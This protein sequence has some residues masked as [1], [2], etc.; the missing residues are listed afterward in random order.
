MRPRWSA[1]RTRVPSPPRW[2][3]LLPAVLALAPLSTAFPQPATAQ[4]GLGAVVCIGSEPGVVAGGDPDRTIPR[5]EEFG[6][7]TDVDTVY[8][9]EA[10]EAVR[11]QLAGYPLIRCARSGPGD[12]HVVV[13]RFS[14]VVRRDD[15][16]GPEDP[17]FTNF[18]I[19][20]G[21]SWGDAEA[22]A[23]TLNERFT[24]YNDGSSYGKFLQLRW[25]EVEADPDRPV[26]PRPEPEGLFRDCDAC[27][28][29]V[30]APAGTFTMGSP[31]S[32]EGRER[33]E[34]PLH[35]VTIG[36][37][38]A[39]GA[40][41]VTFAEW[42]A[43]ELAGDC[44]VVRPD[45]GVEGRDRYPVGV[46]WV[47][48]QAYVAWLS[49]ETGQRYRLLSEAEWEYVARAGTPGMR[50]WGDGEAGQCEHANAQDRVY[51]TERPSES[52]AACSDGYAGPA[53]VGLYV[54][55]AFG[56]HD[57]LGNRSEWTRD[58]WNPLYA[59]A[60]TD[61]SAW[62]AGNC[63]VRVVRGGGSGTPPAALRA[64]ARSVQ[65]IDYGRIGFRV[66][67]DLN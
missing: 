24:T 40:Y 9:Q 60:P 21:A 59:G 12:T 17:R 16:V 29:M 48:A 18:A 15:E 61:G 64:A 27:P 56:L 58:C 4:P 10:E 3:R 32:E 44:E 54:P 55:N 35:Q 67:R 5:D 66:A 28:G 37:P 2:C 14:A 49:A 36:A 8:M 34:Q 63:G 39:V 1:S 33:N 65:A 50:Y 20:F 22:R 26:V 11:E 45:D 46:T 41:E 62:E 31:D 19:G 6:Y 57:I 30:V 47:Q 52:A 51:L 38:F 23:T 43:C 53:P 25:G 7:V 42:A 13:V